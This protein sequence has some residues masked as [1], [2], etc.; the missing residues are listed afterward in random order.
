VGLDL[1]IVPVGWALGQIKGKTLGFLSLFALGLGGFYLTIQIFFDRLVVANLRQVIEV[2]RR[3]FPNEPIPATPSPSPPNS[4]NEIE[5]IYA[6][7][8][9]LASRLKDARNHIEEYTRNLESMVATRTQELALEAEE[10]RA[11]VALFVD[12]L[13]TITAAPTNTELLR[14]A[15]PHIA[16]RF[17]ADWAFYHCGSGIGSLIWPEDASVP[18][19]PEHWQ[20]LIAS[21][22]LVILENEV[23]IS[24]RTT[25]IGRGILRLHFSDSS[26]H[27]MTHGEE[28]YRAIGHQLALAL[29]NLDAIHSLM[30]HN[31]L[32]ESIFSGISDPLALVDSTCSLI[33]ANEPARQLARSLADQDPN[34]PELHLPAWIFH[35]TNSPSEAEPTAPGVSSI[36]LKDGRSFVVAR[37]PIPSA[38]EQTQRFVVYARENTAERRMVERLV[39]SERMVTV[40]RLA[41]GLAHEVNNPLGVI[42]CYT[43]LLRHSITDPGCLADIAIIE[44]HATMAKKVVRDLL[45][46]AR[47]RPSQIAPCNLTELFDNLARIFEVQAQARHVTLEMDLPSEPVLALA[48][49]SALEQVLSNIVLNALDAVPAQHGRI[50]IQVRAQEEDGGAVITVA[51]NGPGIP[52]AVLPHIFDPFFSTKEVGQGTG[53]GL[54]VAFG[55]MRDMNG[56]IEAHNAN[57][58]VFVLTLPP[59]PTT[60]PQ[61]DA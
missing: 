31:A 3:H 28:L 42:L 19:P 41:A 6:G 18:P 49:T 12:L 23:L 51:D 26:T 7:I 9:A 33:L 8:D 14:L 36:T 20:D 60:P 10:R 52:E 37:Y 38:P 35:A 2:L 45:D 29:E 24:V 57:G 47:P 34:T 4:S 15:L 58:A 54:A 22:E 21:G 30:A 11:D 44:R 56:S 48:D 32:L 13:Q 59:C 17:G 16:Q 40:G 53:L 43:E 55:L 46:F 50:T 27:P 39:H 1:V 5:E 61:E 25:E